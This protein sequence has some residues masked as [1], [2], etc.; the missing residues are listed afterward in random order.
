MRLIRNATSVLLL[1]SMQLAD[2]ADKPPLRWC[3]ED[4]SA[5]PWTRPDGTGLNLELLKAA[6]KDLH[7]R[8][9]Y[10]TRPWRRCIK[11]MRNG[12]FDGVFAAGESEERRSF[13]VFPSL[14]GGATDTG[15]ALHEDRFQ[16]F[17]LKGSAASW[18]GKTLT[19]T[20]KGVLAQRGYMIAGDL[21]EKG[22]DVKEATNSASDALRQIAAGMFDIAVIQGPEAARLLHT[23]SALRSKVTMSPIPYAVRPM[24][25]L[26]AQP[27]YATDPKRIES[28]WNYIG[29]VR[30]S[31]QYRAKE[32]KALQLPLAE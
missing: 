9:V 19:P 24:Y 10:V 18:D 23:N 20:A 22:F 14:P 6:E 31:P 30:K 27:I 17:M 11:E 1:L 3:Y 8:F 7:E 12:D 4:V 16:V 2:A 25:L 5:M 21:R 29:E 13:G 26:V 32:A 28:I 15:R